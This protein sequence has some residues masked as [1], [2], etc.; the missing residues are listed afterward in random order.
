MLA[1]TGVNN[2]IVSNKGFV[3]S[4]NV[5]ARNGFIAAKAAE[6]L[7]LL[8]LVSVIKSTTFELRIGC[9]A[10]DVIES[11]AL[12]KSAKSSLLLLLFIASLLTLGVGSLLGIVGPTNCEKSANS[13]PV[14]DSDKVEVTVRPPNRSPRRSAVFVWL[15]LVGTTDNRSESFALDSAGLLLACSWA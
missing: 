7:G 13:S 8:E 6:S 1:A 12:W 14:A 15:L 3:G 11:N 10:F 2:D 4:V 9:T 5:V